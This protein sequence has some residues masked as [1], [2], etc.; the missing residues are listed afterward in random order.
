HSVSSP[1]K[2]GCRM[3]ELRKP[4]PRKVEDLARHLVNRPRPR[5]LDQTDELFPPMF[6]V[7]FGVDPV[8]L[9]ESGWGVVFHADAGADGRSALEPLLARR[10]VQA[11]D[12]FAELDYRRGEQMRDW[13]DRHGIS[14]GS[15][16]PEILPY[17]LLLVGPPD[18]IPFEFQYLVGIEYAVGRVAFATPDESQRYAR[19]I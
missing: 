2:G 15:V 4:F 12:R 9:A 10:R 14:A 11:G 6:G 18:L 5:A 16:D 19:S 3:R 7:R 13:Y 17:Y 8:K 1:Q